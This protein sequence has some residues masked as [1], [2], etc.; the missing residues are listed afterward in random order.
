[1][2]NLRAVLVH[3]QVL[4][5]THVVTVLDASLLLATSACFVEHPSYAFTYGQ[6][7]WLNR[8]N[9]SFLQH[10]FYSFLAY[11]S[12]NGRGSVRSVSRTGSVQNFKTRASNLRNMLHTSYQGHECNI[13][14]RLNSR[15]TK[16]WLL[17]DDYPV[18]CSVLCLNFFVRMLNRHPQTYAISDLRSFR[19]VKIKLR[20]KGE[21]T[22]LKRAAFFLV[23]MTAQWE[24]DDRRILLGDNTRGGVVNLRPIRSQCFGVR[25]ST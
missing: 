16:E 3:S 1:M 13:C 2:F 15:W 6:P 14:S 11:V 21:V 5:S 17:Q 22:F 20:K 23:S 10:T 9:I 25:I 8:P 4:S 12:Y 7:T 24:K 18:K 19:K